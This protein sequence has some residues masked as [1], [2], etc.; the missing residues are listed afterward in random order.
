MSITFVL[1]LQEK[2]R[3]RGLKGLPNSTKTKDDE[4]EV[5]PNRKTRRVDKEVEG[6]N[7]WQNEGEGKGSLLGNINA[8]VP[9]KLEKR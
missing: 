7:R 3:E 1:G 5:Y 4:K 2:K 9:G 8:L 6:R